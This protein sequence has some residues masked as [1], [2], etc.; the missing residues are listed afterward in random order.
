MAAATSIDMSSLAPWR[1]AKDSRKDSDSWWTEES[2][3]SE[4][5]VVAYTTRQVARPPRESTTLLL[6][7]Q[8]KVDK[9]SIAVVSGV[10]IFGLFL[11][12]CSFCTISSLGVAFD[13]MTHVSPVL[14]LFWKVTG[15]CLV[16]S[17]VCLPK[18]PGIL[19][20]TVPVPDRSS[21]LACALGY[22]LWNSTFLWALDHTSVDHAYILNNSHSLVLVVGKILWRRPIAVQECVG[23]VIGIIGGVITALDHSISRTS[24]TGPSLKGD[25][26]AFLGAIGAAIYL[27]NAKAVRSQPGMNFMVFMWLHM[28]SVAVI[29][30]L[31]L[32]LLGETITLSADPMIGLFGW[33]DSTRLPLELYLVGV[34]DFVG[35]MGYIRVLKYFEP[36]VVS[37]V[38]L[39]EP[40]LASLLGIAVGVSNMPGIMTL[41]GS[42]VVIIGTAMVIKSSTKRRP[43]PIID[44][45]SQTNYGTTT[46]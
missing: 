44:I 17:C 34:C 30:L 14:K 19:R 7:M 13:L 27:T 43:E 40:V 8:P 12:L 26:V 35:G 4:A 41:V 10:P 23:T 2:S 42:F 38:M 20:G 16:T 39:M 11:L 36:I 15:T 29:L 5:D 37:I 18:I 1:T 33:L 6:K 9:P 21:L 46:A 24:A 25:F 31:I 3:D 28:C 45:V 22:C 32:L